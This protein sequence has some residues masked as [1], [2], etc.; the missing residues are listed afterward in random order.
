MDCRTIAQ[1]LNR[2]IDGRTT[3]EEESILMQHIGG[4]SSCAAEQALQR[5]LRRAFRGL[6]RPRC[7]DG[8]ASRVADRIL[9]S[10]FSHAARPR[11]PLLRNAAALLL[12]VTLAGVCGWY[13]AQGEQHVVAGQPGSAG[14]E[15]RRIELWRGL[16]ATR[17]QAAAIIA[18]D[19]RYE[20]L[21]AGVAGVA[22]H[23][24]INDEWAGAVLRLLPEDVRERYRLATGWSEAEVARLLAIRPR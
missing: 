3:P 8:L 18:T 14:D 20:S 23:R 15:A 4:C 13:A 21:L 19:A 7:P 11:W 2:E 24:R 6:P 10:P 1:L 22:E 9:A 17:E 5:D 12:T 16:G